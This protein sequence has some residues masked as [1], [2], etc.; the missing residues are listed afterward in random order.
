MASSLDFQTVFVLVLGIFFLVFM[1]LPVAAVDSAV[2]SELSLSF[3]DDMSQKG[4]TILWIVQ[5]DRD[6]TLDTVLQY[7]QIPILDVTHQIERF[8]E[9]TRWLG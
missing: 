6:K 2:G 9:C 5:M 4:G 7:N 8:A 3:S 1:P